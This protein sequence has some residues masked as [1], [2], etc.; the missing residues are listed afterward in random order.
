MVKHK[1]TGKLFAQKQL[2]KAS[3]IVRTKIIGI[4]LSLPAVLI[5]EYTKAERT[6]LEEIKNPFVV[7]LFFAFQDSNKLYLILEVCLLQA[8]LTV[9][10]CGRGIIPPS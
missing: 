4:I 6:I 8:W 2:K 9:V 10:C 7:K 3:L 1:T 5:L